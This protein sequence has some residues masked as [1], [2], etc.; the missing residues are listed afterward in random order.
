[1]RSILR[2]A[3]VA[4]GVDGF[5]KKA[6]DLK[7]AEDVSVFDDALREANAVVP[8]VAGLLIEWK[9][10]EGV[11]LHGARILRWVNVNAPYADGHEKVSLGLRWL[12]FMV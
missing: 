3:V 11:E 9:S 8:H 12:T 10:V 7:N 1:M 6:V 5:D 4:A 2:G